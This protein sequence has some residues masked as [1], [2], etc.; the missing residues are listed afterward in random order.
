MAIA[1]GL[2]KTARGSP[3]TMAETIACIEA[4]EFLKSRKDEKLCLLLINFTVVKSFDRERV[5]IAFVGCK[6]RLA[7]AKYTFSILAT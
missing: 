6:S 4:L 3:A 7:F 2:A 5:Y 1:D